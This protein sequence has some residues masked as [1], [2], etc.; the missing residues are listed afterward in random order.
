METKNEKNKIYMLLWQYL[1][2]KSIYMMMNT[3]FNNVQIIIEIIASFF[4]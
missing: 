3:K 4:C 2:V 1:Y